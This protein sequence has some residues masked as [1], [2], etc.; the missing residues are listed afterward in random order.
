VSQL[1]ESLVV[2]ESAPMKPAGAE[3]DS[4]RKCWTKSSA[5]GL[6]E[7]LLADPTVS[8]IL[9]NTYKRIYIERRGILEATPVQFPR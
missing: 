2:G 5:W 3:S 9:V 7:P 4:R 6:F 1:L 8:D